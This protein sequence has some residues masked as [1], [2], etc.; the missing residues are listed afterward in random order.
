M[1][2]RTLEA[3][4]GLHGRG[5]KAHGTIEVYRSNAKRSWK[6]SR[7]NSMLKDAVASE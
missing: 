5:Q 3:R 7:L 1:A 4:I 6:L 2:A